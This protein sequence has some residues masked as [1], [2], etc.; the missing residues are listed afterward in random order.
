[1]HGA[2]YESL[3]QPDLTYAALVEFDDRAGLVAEY[4]LVLEIGRSPALEEAYRAWQR[5][6][7]LRIAGKLPQVRMRA[8]WLMTW[9]GLSVLCV[10]FACFS[11]AFASFA[12]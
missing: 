12:G 6:L 3:S 4:E 9:H 10:F 1:M 2:G 11:R 7:G 8:I 5:D